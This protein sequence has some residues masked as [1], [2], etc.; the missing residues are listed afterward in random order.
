LEIVAIRMDRSVTTIIRPTAAVNSLSQRYDPRDPAVGLPRPDC[1]GYNTRAYD[2]LRAGIDPAPKDD[3]VKG[4]GLMK[5]KDVM[6][7]TY[8][9][10]GPDTSFGESVARLA[11]AKGPSSSGLASLLVMDG[12]RL[13]GIVT[14]TDLLKTLFPSL[15][16]D[17]HLAS[18][19][20]EGLL[21]MQ[22]NK[23]RGKPVREFMTPEVFT[24]QDTAP[25]TMAAELFCAHHIQSL[26]VLRDNRIAGMI[27]LADLSR[28]IF[29]D[30]AGPAR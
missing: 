14:V 11:R 23:M 22:F 12:D 2:R 19:A 27:Y 24:I 6:V 13:A 17:P 4:E 5:V 7:E 29:S 28:R 21:E 30:F 16:Q 15:A 9:A 25:I 10:V 1:F 3:P 26:P 20:W 18:M 8:E